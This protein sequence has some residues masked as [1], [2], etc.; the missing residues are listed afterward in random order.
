MQVTEIVNIVSQIG[1]PF[2]CFFA[3]FYLCD[4][5]ITEVTDAITDLNQTVAE[6][7]GALREKTGEG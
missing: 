1:I 7:K 6:L 5:T 4:K 2:A 3:M